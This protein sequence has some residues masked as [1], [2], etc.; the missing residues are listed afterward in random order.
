MA[1]KLTFQARKR[2]VPLLVRVRVP[3]ALLGHQL[4]HPLGLVLLT[5]AHA[6]SELGVDQLGGLDGLKKKKIRTSDEDATGTFV[7][8]NIIRAVANTIC[9]PRLFFIQ[10][11]AANYLR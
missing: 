3:G 5:T 8:V 11:S 1:V 10:L 7:H 9:Q 4:G 6:L 2:S